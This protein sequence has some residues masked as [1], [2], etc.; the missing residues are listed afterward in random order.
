MGSA[1]A[2]GSVGGNTTTW[3]SGSGSGSGRGYTDADADDTADR[4]S[5]DTNYRDTIDERDQHSVMDQ[6][7]DGD[8]MSDDGDVNMGGFG[9]GTGSTMS[10][11]TYTRSR[12]SVGG[13]SGTSMGADTTDRILREKTEDVENKSQLPMRTPEEAGLGKSYFDENRK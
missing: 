9:G 8:G 11:P 5:M 13:M 1:S 3:L 4:M 12:A 10:G 7:E 2:T 6:S